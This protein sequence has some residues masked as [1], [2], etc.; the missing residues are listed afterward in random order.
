MHTWL[1]TQRAARRGGN[2][3]TMTPEREVQ[4][5][6]LR[7]WRWD[8][9]R[10]AGASRKKEA[11]RG[12]SLSLPRAEERGTSAQEAAVQCGEEQDEE[13]EEEL[14]QWEAAGAGAGEEEE[15]AQAHPGA[16]HHRPQ[17]RAC[18]LPA[19]RAK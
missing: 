6:S 2:S 19:L 4:L 7:G 8:S 18:P 14:A 5:E 16:A 1:Y 10:T 3:C 13:E 15:E 17:R 12:T 11:R 9:L